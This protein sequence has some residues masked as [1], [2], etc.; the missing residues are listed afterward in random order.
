MVYGRWLPVVQWSISG[1][2]SLCVPCRQLAVIG[3]HMSSGFIALV[4]IAGGAERVYPL[5]SVTLVQP[6]LKK[7]L[8]TTLH[9]YIS[10]LQEGK[11]SMMIFL[12]CC[13]VVLWY[14][15]ESLVSIEMLGY[16][17]PLCFI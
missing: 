7:S 4:L 15:V 3:C 17:C 12:F 9:H 16:E 11:P 1:H 5:G 6:I 8:P 14:D 13:G 2:F 10:P